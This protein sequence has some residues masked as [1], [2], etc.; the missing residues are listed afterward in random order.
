MTNEMIAEKVMVMLVLFSQVFAPYW[1][2]SFML[3]NS[4]HGKVSLAVGGMSGMLVVDNAILPSLGYPSINSHCL[5]VC[6]GFR[7]CHPFVSWH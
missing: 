5:Q 3:Q 1:I 7:D 4:S 2:G 6:Q